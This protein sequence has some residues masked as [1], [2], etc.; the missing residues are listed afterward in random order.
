[1]F[2]DYAVINR[3]MNNGKYFWSE[4]IKHFLEGIHTIQVR[5]VSSPS[6]LSHVDETFSR[7]QR[8][9]FCVK[10]NFDSYTLSRL[11]AGRM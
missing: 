2:T 10:Y 1:M 11:E 9:K 7:R 8:L 6:S 4:S 3:H 5:R